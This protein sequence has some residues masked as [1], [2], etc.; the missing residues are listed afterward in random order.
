[1]EQ[2]RKKPVSRKSSHTIS[3]EK[4]EHALLTVLMVGRAFHCSKILADMLK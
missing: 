3:Y 4:T 1:M 2:E